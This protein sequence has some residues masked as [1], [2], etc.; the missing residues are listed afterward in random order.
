MHPSLRA[1]A[2]FA[3]ILL[4]G[5]ACTRP[6]EGQESPPA[7]ITSPQSALR[8]LQLGNARFVRSMRTRSADTA[9]DIPERRKLREGQHPIVA[10]LS[11][12]DSRVAPEYIFDQRPGSI[13]EVRNAGNVVDEDVLA[14]LEYAIE[15]LHA[16]LVAV[17]GHKSCGAVRAV[18]EAGERTLPEHLHVLQDHMKAVREK[19]LASGQ[20]PNTALIDRLCA[21]NSG[22]QAKMILQECKLLREA[23]EAGRSMLIYG[24]Y[25]MESGAVRWTTLPNASG[26]VESRSESPR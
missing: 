11:C 4:A 5:G 8:E 6:E 15:H 7:A 18:C 1:S 2:P 14:S 22:Q 19:A 3:I 26:G 25:D 23:I 12:A 24:T 16:P 17:L 10:M 13:F 9:Q 21:E 20:L